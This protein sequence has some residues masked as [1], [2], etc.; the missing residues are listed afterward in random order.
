MTTVDATFFSKSLDRKVTYSAIIP[1]MNREMRMF[2]TLYLFH[3]YSGDRKDW[4]YAGQVEQLAESYNI[5]IILPSGENSYYVDHPNGMNY[6]QFVGEELI[7]ESRSLFPLSCKRE[8]TW[9]AGLSM[10][11]YGALRNGLYYS[12][13]FG[14]IAALSSRIITKTS[15]FEE[16]RYP[17][18]I[19]KV[20]IGSQDIQDIPDNID[21]YELAKQ[22]MSLPNIYM[23]CGTSD[24][25][26]EDNVAFHNELK[27]LNIKHDYIEDT[28][29]HNWNFWNKHIILAIDWLTKT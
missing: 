17:E 29:D 9:I 1:K 23:A 5:A 20:L 14:K 3:G 4:F 22:S 19:M 12:E 10:G 25:L 21:L 15:E 11:G 6:G 27:R 28:G 2:K 16:D 13:T 18:R 7:E 24:F 26:Y 8:E